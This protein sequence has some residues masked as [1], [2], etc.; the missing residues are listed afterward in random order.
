MNKK[1]IRKIDSLI[2]KAQQSKDKGNLKNTIGYLKK[3]L[4]LDPKNEKALNNIG[5]AF[6]EL[7]IYE[8]ALI[9]Y[10]KAININKNYIIAKINLSILYHD[11]GK[12]DEA[13]KIYSELIELDKYNFAVYFNLSRIDFK[14]FDESRIKFIK[15][16]IK[17]DFINNYN[18]ASGYFV[19]AKNEQIKKNYKEEM[20]YLEN[21]HQHFCESLQPNFYKQSLNYWLNIIPKKYNKIQFIQNNKTHLDNLR[22]N[23]IFITG[24]PRSGSTLVESIISSGKLRIPNGGETAIINS[25]LIQNLRDD[26]FKKNLE[27]IYIDKT[28]LSEKIIQ[29]YQNLNLLEKKNKFFFTD[30]SLENFFYIDIIIKLF[31]NA[32]IIL[33]KRN[34]I[35]NIFAIYQ[36]FFTKMTWTHSLDNIMNYVDNYLII[37][38]NSLTK[39]QNHILIIELEKLTVDSRDVSK[40]IFEFCGLEWTEDSL[41]YYQRKDLFA[42]TASNIQIREKIF[43]YNS[44]KYKDYKKFIENYVKQYSWLEEY[45][46]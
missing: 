8:E 28:K 18:K 9:Y 30:K 23:P 31:P 44:L 40:K 7:K 13:K 34:I 29:K 14:Y 38:K 6:K 43:K 37:L 45:F 17:S 3:I 46:F 26:L 20:I 35:D 21:A 2:V 22:I 4:E 42:T 11:L 16:N 19:L 1:L 25:T 41:K 32:K 24:L 12:L 36:N 33:C 15:D 27:N 10:T 5:N 39:Y